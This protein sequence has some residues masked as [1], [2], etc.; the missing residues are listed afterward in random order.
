MTLRPAGA[1][2]Y[3]VAVDA[4]AV[5]ARLT[6]AGVYVARVLAGLAARDDLEVE[7]FCAPGSAGVLAA[8]GLRLRPVAMAGAGRP[9][10]IA[11]TQLRAGR[12]ARRPGPTRSTT[13][14]TTSCPCG[15]ACPR[16]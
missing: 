16:W 4:T 11:W 2:A 10:R 14:S 5:P 8:L 3:R 1:P 15:P 12:V 7:A 6:G 13:A 9:A